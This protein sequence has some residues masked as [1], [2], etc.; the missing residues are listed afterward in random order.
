MGLFLRIVL[1]LKVIYINAK[2][3]SGIKQK[4]E[5]IQE[6][7]RKGI[8]NSRN[9]CIVKF[10]CSSFEHIDNSNQFV[11]K[12]NETVWKPPKSSKKKSFRNIVSQLFFK[13]KSYTNKETA[14]RHIAKNSPDDNSKNSFNR[15]LVEIDKLTD[16]VSAENQSNPNCSIGNLTSAIPQE[17]DSHGLIKM[18]KFEEYFQAHDVTDELDQTLS[19]LA[20]FRQNE[21]QPIASESI[22][23]TDKECSEQNDPK[24]KEEKDKVALNKKECLLNLSEKLINTQKQMT[25]TSVDNVGIEIGSKDESENQVKPVNKDKDADLDANQGNN[26]SGNFSGIIMMNHMFEKIWN[27]FKE[28]V[29]FILA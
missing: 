18:Q 25:N 4:N 12:K 19:V 3:A 20:E 27:G 23:E 9:T 14:N 7:L 8:K 2:E 6:T 11:G 28:I 21:Q 1:F 29:R 26:D 5:S 22:C 10:G 13:K 15:S 17:E 24:L 16:I